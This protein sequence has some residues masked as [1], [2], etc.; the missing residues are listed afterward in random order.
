LTADDG[1][2]PLMAAVGMVQNEARQADE[3]EALVLV[4][5][6]VER[7]IDLD[8]VDRRG[9]TAVHGAAR[10]ARNDLITLLAENWAQVDIADTRG[11]TPLDVGT[12][13]RPL[14]PDTAALLRRLGVTNAGETP[15][16][17]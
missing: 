15:A 5:L 12:V 3:S 1:T 11:Q 14:H 2:T 6:L 4:R 16:R 13:S 9:R 7:D 8:A 17:R 10:L